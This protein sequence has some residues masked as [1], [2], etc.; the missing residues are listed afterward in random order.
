M[1]NRTSS[2]GNSE[3]HARLTR[4]LEQFLHQACI[5][6]DRAD[7]T[8][9][10]EYFSLALDCEAKLRLADGSMP[11]IMKS[12]VPALGA[13][14]TCTGICAAAEQTGTQAT[15]E[16]ARDVPMSCRCDRTE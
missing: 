5:A 2:T 1:D 14:Q 6:E 16:G 15:A 7:P 3:R 4:M 12:T 10:N 11:D 8:R 13:G 9:A